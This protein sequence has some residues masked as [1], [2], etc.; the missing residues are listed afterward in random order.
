MPFYILSL[1]KH[2]FSKSVNSGKV[3]K[4]LVTR[5]FLFFCILQLHK[6][7][8]TEANIYYI[9][10]IIMFARVHYYNVFMIPFSFYRPLKGLL[11]NGKKW[12]VTSDE[13]LFHLL[14]FQ[15]AFLL[16]AY[17]PKTTS[18]RAA[19]HV[20]TQMAI[21]RDAAPTAS[22]RSFC[23]HATYLFHRRKRSNARHS[24][25]LLH[26]GDFFCIFALC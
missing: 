7:K 8:K 15:E 3:K 5:H 12:K 13:W 4:S 2:S 25:Q 20:P 14:G 21:R 10:H 19:S 1:F 16:S 6:D 9:I 22:G 18:R 23:P 24:G 26:F 17:L 11:K